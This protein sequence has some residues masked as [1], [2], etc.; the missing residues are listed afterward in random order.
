M[1]ATELKKW[2][3]ADAAGDP[4]ARIVRLLSQKGSL[5]AAEI[6]RELNL[7]KS[8]VSS[9]LVGLRA[10]G[11]VVNAGQPAVRP[12][13]GTG[14]PATT[15]SLNPSAGACVGVL[16]CDNYIRVVMADVSHAILDEDRCE[17]P[18]DYS[19][20]AAARATHALVKNMCKRCD[21]RHEA[22]LGVGVAVPG[23]VRPDTGQVLRASVVP[24]WAGLDIRGPFEAA[25]DLPIFAD[26]ESNCAAIAEMT[27]GAA[28]G[29]D[30]FVYF[31]IDTG[32][33]GAIVVNRRIVAGRAGG[34]GEFGHMSVNP[35][36]DLCL[37]GGRGCLE[38]YAGFEGV[39]RHAAR[40]HGPEISIA[41]VVGL[42]QSGNVGCRRL[43]AD[44][45]EAAGHGLALIGTTFNP[46]LIV[47]GGRGALAGELVLAPLRAAYERFA[48]IKNSEMPAEA[49]TRIIPG[50]FL[51]NDS[52]LG[53]VGLVLRYHGRLASG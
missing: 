14:R 38:L 6:A 33:G 46:P 13:V 16:V 11:M 1:N 45:G 25:F 4:T 31:K 7:A 53:A 22:L 8:T 24:T 21:V 51:T 34:A 26:N 35:S 10:S 36:G 12:Q 5:S 9:A 42:A 30:D 40:V 28:V 32:I 47:I 49:Q 44:A 15:L 18:I 43:I 20:E 37:C 41:E 39:L 52:G 27:W 17:M 48:L 29:F 50:A 23:P 19:P 3:G 2:L